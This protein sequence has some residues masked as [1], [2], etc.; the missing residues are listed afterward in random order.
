[1][2]VTVDENDKPKLFLDE[3]LL[4]FHKN[5]S[6]FPASKCTQTCDET[7]IKIREVSLYIFCSYTRSFSF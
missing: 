2:C 1:M 3:T 6:E 7:Q 4:R 5:S